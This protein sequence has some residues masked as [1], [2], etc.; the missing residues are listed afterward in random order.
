M[1]AFAARP[2]DQPDD[3]AYDWQDQDP[4]NPE[5][6]GQGR[7][8]AGGGEGHRLQSHQINDATCALSLL[9]GLSQLLRTS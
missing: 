3:E 4:E 9:T 8:R 6:L 1:R 2:G 7:G 5:D